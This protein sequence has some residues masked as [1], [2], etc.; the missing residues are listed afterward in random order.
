M[1]MNYVPMMTLIK[2]L[3]LFMILWLYMGS[4]L[5]LKTIDW[6]L[7]EDSIYLELAA[8]AINQVGPFDVACSNIMWPDE[9]LKKSSNTNS[10]VAHWVCCLAIGACWSGL[11]YYKLAVRWLFGLIGLTLFVLT[12]MCVTWLQSI[13]N[14]MS[15]FVNITPWPR[16]NQE[17]AYLVL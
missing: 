1:N 3:G 13:D 8:T 6:P 14:A 7:V 2:F 4:Y 12:G 10:F 15:W 16:A 17:K 11:Y 5:P 9:I